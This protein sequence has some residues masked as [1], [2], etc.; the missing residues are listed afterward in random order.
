MTYDLTGTATAGSDYSDAGV[1]ELTI[2]A[3]DTTATITLTVSDDA[4]DEMTETVIVTLTGVTTGDADITVA[5]GPND[6]ATRD[7][8]DDDTAGITV[9]AIS[10]DTTEAGDTATF[11]I[12]LDSQ[13][14][15]DVT[16]AISSDDV[17][18]GTVAPASVTFTAANWDTPQTVTVTGVDDDVD[19]SDV[20]FNIVLAAATSTDPS[21][22]AVNPADVAV[23]NIDDDTAGITVSA[24]SGATTE[25]GGTATFTIVLDSEPTGDVT[26]SIS[27]D[28]ATEGT[29]APLSVTFTAANWDTPQ[30]VTVTGQ[31]EFVDDGNVAFNIVLDA[32]TSTDPLY[33]G[34]DPDDV[35]VTN[36]DDDVSGINV[37]GI[38]GNTSEAGGTA[39]FT[40]SLQSQPTADVTIGIS[41]DDTSEGTVTPVSLTF[42]AANWN[43]PQTVTVTGQDDFI[44][45]GN[46]S[47]TIVT[48]T[49]A[50]GDAN[51]DGVNAANVTVSN[52]DDDTAGITVG[53]ISGDTTEAGGMATFTIVLDSEPTADVTIGISSDDTTEGTGSPA[54]VIFTAANWNVPQTVTVTGVDDFVDDGDV[55]FN[56]VTAA[57]TSADTVYNGLNAANV[58]VTNTDDDT[59]GITVGAISGDTTEAGGT[60]TFTIVLDSEPTG[61]VTIGVSS[62]DTTE[63]TVAPASVTFTAANWNVPQTVTV[64]GVNDFVDDGDVS[65]NIVLGAATS[66]DTNYNGDN[67]ADVA[68]TNLD[69]DT[70]GI[71]VGTISGDT[72][73]A[74]GTATFT[75]VLDSEPTGDVTIGVSSD[76][77]SEGTVVPA[78][79]T[80]TAANWNVPQTLTVTGVDDFVDDG[81]V[82]FNVV[83]DTATSTD[84]NYSSIDP[85]D[86]AV[87]NTDDDTAGITVSAISGDTT[88]AGG[89]A[90]FTIV[91][92]SEPTAD[93]TIGVYSNNSFEG[94]SAAPLGLTF[95]AANWNVPQTVTVTG[96]DDFVDDGDINF[97][98]VTAPAISIDPNYFGVDGADVAVTN[99]D[100][101]TAGITVTPTSGLITTEAGG[102]DTFTIVLDSEPTADVTIAISS[103]NTAEGTAA[104]ASVTFTAANWNV[105]Q[106]VTV[107]GVDD[108]AADGDIAFSILTDPATSTDPNYAALDADDV[109][110]TNEDD[111]PGTTTSVD[112][113]GNLV[114]DDLGGESNAFTFTVVGTDLVITDA[115][116]HALDVSG[117]AGSTGSGTS[118][119]TIPLSAFTNGIIVNS[120]DGDDTLTLDFSTGLIIPAA[121]LTFNGGLGQDELVLDNTD[122]QFDE[123]VLDYTNP[124]DGFITLIGATT[125]N[126]AYTGLDP[127]TINGPLASITFNLTAGADDANLSDVGGGQALLAGATF[128]D[129]TFDVPTAG[130][131]ITINLLGGNDILT[132]SSLALTATTD[133]T[134]NGGADTD[135]VHFNTTGG[136]S[137]VDDLTVSAET[138]SQ[139]TSITAAGDASFT[140]TTDLTLT[141]VGNDFNTIS[142]S[143]NGAVSI[144]DSNSMTVNSVTGAGVILSTVDGLTVSGAIDAGAG[145]VDI[146]V[147]TNAA[148]AD[149]FVMS[150]GS[151][152]VT[153][154]DTENAVSI[155]VNSMIGGTGNAKLTSISAGTTGGATG[156]RV[157]VDAVAGAITDGDTSTTNNI[158][159]G[160]AVLTAKGGV[161]TVADPIETTLSRLEGTSETG[162]FFVTNTG[163]LMIGGVNFAVTGISSSTGNI[164]V[165]VNGSL[166]VEE[167]VSSTGATGNI[168]L[169]ANENAGTGRDLTINAVTIS[170]PN[171]SITLEAGDN[172]TTLAGSKISAPTGTIA[173]N[174]DSGGHDA[175]G[176]TINL[177]GQLVSTGTTVSGGS[178]DDSY[179][180]AYP[181]G[182]TNK[183]TVTISDIGGT[184]A[185]T[186]SGTTADDV[187][188]FTSSNPPTTTTTDQVTRGDAVSEPVVIPSSIEAVTL[189]G[190]NGNDTFT[191]EPSTL[192]ALTVDGGSPA[193]G[194]A[195]VPPGDQLNLQTFGNTFSFVGSSIQVA[196]TQGG[197]AFKLVTPTNIEN[198]PLAPASPTAPQRYDFNNQSY[199]S[200]TNSF[201]QTETQAGWT[202]M[203]ADRVYSVANGYGWRRALT[204]YSG[205]TSTSADANLIN[206][207]HV[208]SLNV[209]SFTPEFIATV[210]NGWVSVTVSYGHRSS[211]ID[212]L[213]IYNGDVLPPKYIVQNLSAPAGQSDHYTFFTQV[214]DGT[215]NIVLEDGAPASTFL[216]FNSIDIRPA[217]IMTMGFMDL[218][219]TP[220]FADG[221]TVDTFHLEGGP[222]N[223][224][225][226][227]EASMGTITSTDADPKIEGFQVLTDANGAAAVSIKRPSG[228]GTSTLLLTTITGEDWSTQS[229][230]Y[231]LQPLTSNARY[232]DF[233]TT[234]NGAPTTTQAGY[235]PV[236]ATDSYNAT[237]GYGWTTT[238]LPS[239]NAPLAVFSG[240][241]AAAHNDFQTSSSAA[242]F[243]VDLP[244]ATYSVHYAMGNGSDHA[245]IDITA[246][247]T[248]VVTDLTLR[249]NTIT[250]ESFLV[251]VTNGRLD[252]TFTPG[253]GSQINGNWVIN[254]LQIVPV[255]QLATITPINE[256]SV[257]ADGSTVSVIEATSSLAPGALVTVS[258]TLGTITTTDADATVAGT[259]VVVGAGGAISFNLKSGTKAGVPTVEWRAVDGSAN[260]TVTNAA[261]LTFTVLAS[262]RF[263]F[264][265]GYDDASMTNIAAGFIGVRANHSFAN[266]GFGWVGAVGA[267]LVNTIPTTV[268]TPD[269]YRDGHTGSSTNIGQ[270]KVQANAGTLYNVRAYVGGLGRRFDA[271]QV[272]VEGTAQQQVATTLANPFA[273][274][275][276]NGASD[277]NNDGYLTITIQSPTNIYRGGWEIVGLEVAEAATGLPP[278]AALT[279]I[280][281]FF[282]NFE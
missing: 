159:A 115:N 77:T 112:G 257:P 24:I 209:S 13:P 250:E 231:A 185:V 245:G 95:T 29:V 71:T 280:D 184:D 67:P 142:A 118:S 31:N 132:I 180:F 166:T 113:S 225:V 42:T 217:A 51:Y 91:L 268:L 152:I 52:T 195:G 218:P 44:D 45:D 108:A 128:E 81:D 131:S 279:A 150:P 65:F 130:G 138:F 213:R 84:T 125:G 27:S 147:N 247:G 62:D 78:S 63:G 53:A 106:T 196:G 164:E 230:Q 170:S 89:T 265:N 239:A 72:S 143:S 26:I 261:F 9:S 25:A 37:S 70:A 207:G 38:S 273:T 246:N 90:T 199:N 74:G 203:T 200:A 173:I 58:A 201:V 61:D 87:T 222:S 102:T 12:V 92:D 47:Y 3:G 194:Q 216:S 111:D 5:A 240:P 210:P 23:T 140:V 48:D 36:T 66:T 162:G 17:T 14:T 182:A 100:D 49:A 256:G 50:S 136:L 46:V 178:E 88:E 80:F 267:Q 278:V 188:F 20:S 233:N 86:V 270:F 271:I 104:P 99:N 272:T 35:A 281:D 274:I 114:F 98:I 202:G 107:T 146:D 124:N 251:T 149:S 135:A 154:N 206:D 177:N 133:L 232:L 237:R 187:L 134:I 59:A 15:G 228:A 73:E 2:P 258:S 244:N 169:K 249:R 156:G 165:R 238:P 119:V 248:Q 259:Q 269:L 266:D 60:A 175:N 236:A 55:S 223:L 1:G 28:D 208:W 263:D 43:V 11:T 105:P 226:T 7:I 190:G 172:I 254:A 18:E 116:G 224:L 127:I 137:N 8:S 75:I 109:A 163:N 30:T 129:T 145:T 19:D 253:T 148:G 144:A 4:F 34:V 221:T 167:G 174:G 220:A 243:R 235:L 204:A 214:T 110:V 141:N 192:F 10:G 33:N 197:S 212:G 6:S 56:V 76:D 93:V 264:G 101:D 189:S 85:A 21:Y 277:T 168:L 126:I 57:A 157:T 151:S 205:G 211:A 82:S 276:A 219:S 96:V 179:Q 241:L 229:I 275:T 22:N 161:G 64:T 282:A 234:V 83:L 139:A 191:V 171:G 227:V 255:T 158:T 103:D 120:G 176:T 193:F 123:A 79:V 40:V 153:T 262:R 242:T 183:G 94:I 186:V 117:F 16:I 252:L 198:I 122:A 32:A 69:N 68:V 155:S 41:S 54:S 97:N 160:N 181:L 215:L 121:G 39:T 260:A